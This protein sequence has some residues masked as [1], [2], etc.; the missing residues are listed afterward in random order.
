MEKKK[1]VNIKITI[2]SINELKS[3]FY[4]KEKIYLETRKFFRLWAKK[5]KL[6]GRG[7]TLGAF[8]HYKKCFDKL[9]LSYVEIIE[10]QN[11]QY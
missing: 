5:L 7:S 1:D 4:S 6:I 3:C 10:H 9:G 11:L 2:T 8:C